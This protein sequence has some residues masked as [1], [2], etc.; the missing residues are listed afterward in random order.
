MYFATLCLTSTPDG[1][2]RRSMKGAIIND[3]TYG[4]AEF[5]YLDIH[6]I[7][8]IHIMYIWIS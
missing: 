5:I 3:V 1:V 6:I 2:T 8:I 4:V 7:Q